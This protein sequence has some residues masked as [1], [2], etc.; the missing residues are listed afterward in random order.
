MSEYGPGLFNQTK[1]ERRARGA[2]MAV[3]ALIAV[4]DVIAAFI[5]AIFSLAKKS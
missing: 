3:S 5:L 4:F 1:E 2:N